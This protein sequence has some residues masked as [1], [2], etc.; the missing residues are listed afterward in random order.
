[1][2]H[3]LRIQTQLREREPLV[4]A[5]RALHH[6]FK[7]GERLTV[8]G[9]AGNRETAQIV[10]GTHSAYDIGFRRADQAYEVVADW[11][12]VEKDT[13]IRQQTFLQ[14][15]QQQYAYNVVREQAKEQDLVWEEE[16]VE[17]NGEIVILLSE[18][19]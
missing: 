5:L 1:M 4:Q 2:S 6:E 11:W 13:P 15:I 7:E 14:Q 18:R 19:G 8:R 3:F 10:V 9:Y 12:G 16:R 17:E